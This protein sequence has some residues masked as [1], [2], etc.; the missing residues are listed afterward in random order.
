MLMNLLQH[1]YQHIDA[2]IFWLKLSFSFVI[3]E[4]MHMS[5]KLWFMC[6]WK[7]KKEKAINLKIKIH[8][9]HMNHSSN[10]GLYIYTW[11]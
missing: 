4:M 8:R 2:I 6:L 9:L 11:K 7:D 3:K 5:Y 10:M 1:L